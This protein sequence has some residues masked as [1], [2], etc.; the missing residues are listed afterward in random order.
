MKTVIQFRAHI[1]NFVH[2]DPIYA[3]LSPQAKATIIDE[4]VYTYRR[5]IPKSKRAA[6]DPEALNT[7][8]L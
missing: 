5:H 3:L 4:A 6:L 2:T 7:P 8:T 1:S